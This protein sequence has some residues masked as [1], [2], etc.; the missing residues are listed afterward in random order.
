[1]AEVFNF[2]PRDTMARVWMLARSRSRERQRCGLA[3]TAAKV[4]NLG[5]KGSVV[6]FVAEV[7]NFAPRDTIRAGGENRAIAVAI[8]V[9]REAPLRAC[10]YC[11]QG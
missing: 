5:H 2:A 8:A 3:A 4:E 6:A 9:A 11:S 7:F 10:G 1:V